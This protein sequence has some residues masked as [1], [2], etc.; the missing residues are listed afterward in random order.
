MHYQRVHKYGDPLVVKLNRGNRTVR[1]K[2]P[3]IVCTSC[4]IE[5]DRADFPPNRRRCIPCCTVYKMEWNRQNPDRAAIH[6]ANGE[7][8]RLRHE[9][10][11]R[12]AR[13][14]LDPDAVLAY[15][16]AHHGR[17]EICGDPPRDGGRDLNMDHDHA[18]GEF[19][20]MLCG[21]C[22]SGLGQ[23]KDDPTRL[24][25]AILYLKRHTQPAP[26]SV[27]GA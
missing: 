11:R 4:R 8:R 26:P 20:G 14:G 16:D 22:N 25:S 24:E 2:P 7:A 21:N 19:R 3:R 12:A 6:F 23:F 10:E 17:C 13:G 27:D 15:Y 1:P 9:L 5:K 18:T